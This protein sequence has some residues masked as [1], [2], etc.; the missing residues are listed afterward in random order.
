[1]IIQNTQT[2][3]ANGST[4]DSIKNVIKLGIGVIYKIEVYFPPGSCGLCNI[5][6]LYNTR[7]IYPLPIDEY[8]RGER[9]TITF[10]D[11]FISD[12]SPYELVVDGYN[13]DTIYDHMGIVRIGFESDPSFIVRYIP[14]TITE[15]IGKLQ[16]NERI[17]SEQLKITALDKLKDMLREYE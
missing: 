10:D 4:A 3:P 11:T 9:N 12:V 7:Q 6:L 8:F 13:S 16:E 5:R 2:Y 1:M 17:K 14:P 15:L